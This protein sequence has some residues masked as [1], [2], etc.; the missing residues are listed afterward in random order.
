MP[1]LPSW[2]RYLGTTVA[3]A[4]LL[5]CAS[6]APHK[7]PPPTEMSLT[8]EP[9]GTT[10]DGTPITLYFMQGTGG[11]QARICNYG[12][13]IVSLKVPDRQGRLGDVVLGYDELADY[14]KDSP[15]FGALIG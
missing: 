2:I 8:S 5:G 14:I 15:Y 10:P 12:G 6:V 9:F 4:S 3:A 13:I 11:A 1:H 7:T